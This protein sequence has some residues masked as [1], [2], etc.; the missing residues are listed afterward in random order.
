ME[1]KPVWLSKTF[2]V[3]IIAVIAMMA[4]SK[5]GFVI[6]VEAQVA[7][8]GVVNMLLRM[9]TKKPVAWKKDSTKVLPVILVLVMFTGCGTKRPLCSLPEA[10]GSVIC[11]LSKKINTTPEAISNTL[12]IA[13]AGGL[14]FDVYEADEADGFIDKIIEKIEQARA[15]GREISYREAVEFIRGEYN[16]LS[17]A[18]QAV[19]E[20][21]DP[22]ILSK[23]LVDMFLTDFDFEQLLSHLYEQKK[24][25]A[26]FKLLAYAKARINFT[27]DMDY[28]LSLVLRHLEKQKIIIAAYL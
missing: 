18:V 12:K 22:D 9:V 7:I 6:D 15:M 11:K 3:N 19:F 25:V 14:A 5:Y 20:I 23:N 24:V 26:V 17:P 1:A 27:A 4:Q 16:Q 8:L 2:W 13:N 28:D 10:D 21:V